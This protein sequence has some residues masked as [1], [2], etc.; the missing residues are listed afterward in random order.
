LVARAMLHVGEG[1]FE[2]ACKELLACHRL[3]RLVG[4]GATL[5][6]SLVGYA[7]EGIASN[8]ELTFPGCSKLDAKQLEKCVHDLQGLSPPALLAEKLDLAERFVFLDS[9]TMIVKG[10][11]PLGDDAMERRRGEIEWDRAFQI[12]NRLYDR[13]TAAL[14]EK[15][16]ASRQKELEQI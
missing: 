12:G 13:I 15:D 2:A 14:R 16:R 6:E 3:G 9:L 8:A 11:S 7:I 4:R 10:A 1:A 5:V